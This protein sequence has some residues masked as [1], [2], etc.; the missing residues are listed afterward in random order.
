M[1]NLRLLSWDDTVEEATR[2]HRAWQL[3]RN[4]L[5]FQEALLW[6]LRAIAIKGETHE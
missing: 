4:E 3:A 2:N 6:Y 5:D 1:P